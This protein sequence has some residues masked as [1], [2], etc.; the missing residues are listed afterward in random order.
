MEALELSRTPGGARFR[1]NGPSYADLARLA[2][3]QPDLFVSGD[4][5]AIPC[6]CGD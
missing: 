5:E 2:A 4:E 6:F 1:L 3:S